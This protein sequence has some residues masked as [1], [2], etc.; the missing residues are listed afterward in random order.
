MSSPTHATDAYA[1]LLVALQDLKDRAE[2]VS[3][4]LAVP[5]AEPARRTRSEL[6]AQLEDYVLPRL[7]RLDAPLLVVVGGSTGAGKSTFVNSLL[8]REVTA[9]GVLRPTTRA[10]VLAHHPSDAD[11]FTS[12]RILPGLA[13]TSVVAHP[14][15]ATVGAAS[16]PGSLHLVA[17]EAVPPGLAI[18]DAPDIDSVVAANR[19]LANQLLAAADLWVFV[20]SAARYAD[21][22]PWAVLRTASERGTS[23]AVVLDRVPPAALEEV[24]EHLAGMLAEQRLG[25]A[26]L[27]AVPESVLSAG[28]LPT[29]AV[30]PVRTW[31]GALSAD[32]AS[33][34][35][36]ARTTLDGA[37]D[38]L[39]AR[40]E[41]I[42]SQADDQADAEAQLRTAAV[43][44]YLLALDEVDAGMTD[45]SL[46]RGEVLARW[47]EFVGTGEL[48]RSLESRV[49]LLRDRAVAALR[50][51]PRP[52][53]GL[54]D[55]LESGIESLVFGSADRAAERTTEAWR[56]LPGGRALLAEAGPRE[57]DRLSRASAELPDLTARAVREWQGSVLDLVRSEGMER[58]STARFMAYGLNGVA[59]LLMVAIFASTAG[60]SGAEVAV[61]GGTSALSQK[62]L[63]AVL[64]DQAV[65]ALA[66]RAKA[67]LQDRVQELMAG[68]RAR[69]RT[70][71][72]DAPVDVDAGASLR[73]AAA[74][75]RSAR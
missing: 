16:D 62:L 71:L 64:G 19:E 57:V 26:P 37:L 24:R 49:G 44:A 13:R 45:G 52:E 43:E 53:Q 72:E 39:A 30:E 42:A 47:Q 25:S 51:R 60:L 55:A 63:E 69:F 73:A 46:L 6:V 23:L 59:L 28:M 14:G 48:L 17:E 27:F 22:V 33:R 9:P 65:R 2:A 5:G 36:V 68:E 32:A 58:R 41:G 29:D 18:V 11:W 67:D 75:V 8:G 3:L 40:V 1:G 21:A 61:A 38:S 10:P 15:G 35:Q 70:L 66:A 74:A 31:L 50:G 56:A 12:G 54:A 34:A 20:T 7:R 4:P